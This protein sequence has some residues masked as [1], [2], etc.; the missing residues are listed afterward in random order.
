MAGRLQPLELAVSL[1]D[2]LL[3][4]SSCGLTD[5]LTAGLISRDAKEP[6]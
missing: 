1:L 6:G 2:F 3:I 5:T 4:F